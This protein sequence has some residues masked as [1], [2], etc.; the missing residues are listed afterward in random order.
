MVAVYRTS[1]SIC[2]YGPLKSAVFALIVWVIFSNP[3][4]TPLLPKATK[5]PGMLQCA[6]DQGLIFY[7]YV[8][9]TDNFLLM[10]FY[11]HVL[12]TINTANCWFSHAAKGT[13]RSLLKSDCFVL[14]G[15]R[16]G[17]IIVAIWKT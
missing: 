13:P 8:F 2:L 9:S 12:S 4:H 11:E 6:R 1:P 14:Y 17:C 15:N 7:S 10:V 16:P 5:Q 3:P